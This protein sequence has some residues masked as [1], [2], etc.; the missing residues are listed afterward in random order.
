ML[1]CNKTV[2][3]DMGLDSLQSR[4]DRAKF[5]WWY[6][7]AKLAEVRYPKQEWN[8]KPRKRKQRKVWSRMAEE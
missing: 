3:E 1:L 8:I 6:K 2:R 4:R 5:K 7:L